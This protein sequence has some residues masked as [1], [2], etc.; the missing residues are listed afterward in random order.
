MRA[1]VEQRA[2]AR[3]ARRENPKGKY[4]GAGMGRRVVSW[5]PPSSGPVRVVEGTERLRDRANDT[6][7]NDWAA[8]SIVQKWATNLVGV[9]IT[10][11]WGDDAIEADAAK[12]FRECDADGVLDFYGLQ[13]LV[14]TTW[15]TGG[16]AF[17]RRRPR[18]LLAP[19]SAPVQIQVLESAMVPYLT[20]DSRE[21]L[22]A[23]HEIV[24]GI[25]RNKRTKQRTAVWF[26]REH[27]GDG[28][29]NAS[30]D[31]LVRVPISDVLHVFRPA[32][33]GQM[34]GVSELSAVMVKLRSAADFES[35]TLD[36]QSLANLFVAFITRQLPDMWEA[37][38][39]RVDANTGVPAF[40]N[41]DGQATVS[42]KSGVVQELNPGESMQFANPP[43]AGT[44]YAEYMRTNHLGTS[45]GAGMPYELMGGDIKDVSDRTL[46]IVIQEFRR[47]C[48][49][50]QWQIL[51][52][53]FC[54]P[55]IAWWAKARVLAGA[56]LS[57]AEKL[58]SPEWFPHGWEYI[59]PVQDVQADVAALDAGL[60]S[61]TG[62]ISKRGDDPRRVL[63]Q[64]KDDAAAEK[65]A[66]LDEP[67]PAKPAGGAQAREDRI[68]DMLVQSQA[69]TQALIGAV[70]ALL[71]REVKT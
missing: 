67:E 5:T 53:Q 33:P 4:D 69:Q 54:Q 19:L 68:L 6:V 13:T 36:R 46:R 40:W 12:W 34:R 43:E 2:A 20:T 17:V 70:A 62:I 44:T 18:S 27:P 25:E 52:P 39:I 16:E 21:G 45:A 59:H 23:N 58:A 9:G 65:A 66:G 61:R 51:I 10:P 37:N 35:N 57:Q 29:V 31:T 1:P 56:A 48:E 11:R 47:L 41:P 30:A 71:N 50:V 64:R 26:Y 24:Q 38:G 63:Q 14:T 22:P 49:Q 8:R 60:K 28:S 7:R 3:R 15:F 32:R 55:A 42:L